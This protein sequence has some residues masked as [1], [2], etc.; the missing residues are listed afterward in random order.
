[1]R[2][3]LLI[4]AVGLLVSACVSSPAEPET[5]PAPPP[6]A[7]EP[8]TSVSVLARELHLSPQYER[9]RD[10]I[11]LEGEPGR[12]VLY[13]GTTVVLVNGARIPGTGKVG[14]WGGEF[15]VKRTDAKRISTALAAD[16]DRARPG[17]P[18]PSTGRSDKSGSAAPDP[19]WDVKLRRT[20]RYIVLHHSGTDSGSAASF[21]RS[22]RNRGWDGLGY[23]FVIGNGHGTGDGKVE[24]GYRWTKQKTGAHAGRPRPSVNL[25]N[26][27]G[28]GIC[29]VG[30]F[31]N[32]P[33][34]KKQRASL[35]RLLNWL[36]ARCGIPKARIL[37]H[38]DCKVT[39]C[40][41]RHF[42]AREF[43]APRRDVPKAYR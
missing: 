23:H 28:I 32:E 17:R 30:N 22:H 36:S 13:P 35:H 39:E 8:R 1:M 14:R 41:G 19:K 26:E 25:L 15:T 43:L 21:D 3:A 2:H 7:Y 5:V 16:A 38:R 10:R 34:T 9:R 29:L 18:G 40:P 31:N 27:Q 20:W 12:V 11:V 6:E 4:A 37:V 42:P 24:V 33:P